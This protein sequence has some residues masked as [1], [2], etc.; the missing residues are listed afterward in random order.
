VPAPSG[1]ANRTSISPKVGKSMTLRQKTLAIVGATLV[2]L[3][4]AFFVLTRMTLLRRFREY[5]HQQTRQQVQ[6]VSTALQSEIDQLNTIVHDEGVWDDAYHFVQHPNRQFLESNFPKGI[7]DELRLDLVMVLNS[8]DQIIFEQAFD[9]ASHQ[10]PLFPEVERQFLNQ[11]LFVGHPGSG[12]VSGILLSAKGP[13]MLASSPVLRS[14]GEGPAAGTLILGRW[15]NEEEVRRLSALTHLAVRIESLDNPQMPAD[16]RAAKRVLSSSAPI[17]DWP[18]DANTVGGYELIDDVDGRPALI[19]GITVPRTIY[20]EGKRTEIY[21]M[22]SAMVV[23]LVFGA[24]TMFLLERQVLSRLV[25]LGKNVADIGGRGDLSARVPTLGSDELSNLTRVINRM[26][27]DLERV[28]QE[29]R[30]QEERY[31]AYVTQSTEGIWRCELQEPLSAS[32]PEPEKL[33]QLYRTT[34]FAECNDALARLH[35]FSSPQQMHG[36]PVRELFDISQSKNLELVHQFLRSNFRIED[37]ESVTAAD[38][39]TRY[40]LNNINGVVENGFLV[41]IWGT[42]REV[43]EQRRLEAQLR[44]AQKMEAIGR[45]AGGVAHDFN[46]L[47]SVI[48]GY[49]EI[50]LRRFS[51]QDAA[52]KEAEQVLRA[53]ERA[54]DLTMQLLAFGRK[55]VLAPKIIDLNSVLAEMSRML[56]RLIREDIELVVR[57]GPDLWMVRADP[58]QMEHVIINLVVNARDAMPNGGRL[59]LET[60]N[61]ALDGSIPRQDPGLGPGQYV[62]LMVSDTGI[63]M[64][65]E[66]RSRVFEPFFTTKELGKGT[67]LGLSTVYGIVEQSGGHITVYSELGKGSVF[68][69]YLPQVE[70]KPEPDI[71]ASPVADSQTAVS[72]TIMLVEDDPAVR[73]LAREVLQDRGY[74]VITAA[75]G[76]EALQLVANHPRIDLLVTDVIMPG[77]AGDELLEHLRLRLPGLKAIF[78]SGY[79]SDSIPKIIPDMFTAFLQKPFPVED[80]VGKVSEMLAEKSASERS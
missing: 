46:N 56:P 58:A 35:G 80:L 20:G 77:M 30:R 34:Y 29:R 21:L 78:V 44:Q 75:N 8:S 37:A 43:T 26:L 28:E 50:L 79:A 16:F 68:K 64:D 9:P 49:S 74:S 22:L 33:E 14:S 54:A 40:F 41:R 63:G 25:R 51:P 66:T 53:T 23:G 31:R 17:V 76:I 19:L 45:L 55:Q 62:V 1:E 47:L 48:H 57:A 32:A 70:G 36:M 24:V 27:A 15:L 6:R 4:A 2:G 11:R 13:M 10:L 69:V 52:Y 60:K 42:Q 73:Q 39:R 18:L 71:L 38:G 59:I 67:G 65:P 5:E 7:F 61:V 12:P 3:M 72:G